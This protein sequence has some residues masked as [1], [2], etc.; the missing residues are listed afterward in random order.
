[1]KKCVL[2]AVT[3]SIAAYKSV[4]LVSDLI[5]KGYDV[6][7]MM[8][9]N[10]TQFIQPLTFSSLTKH[11]TYVDTFDRV[12]HYEV[13]HISLAKKADVV[14]IAPASANVIAK[15]AHGICD[16]MLTTTFLA[17][18]AP[19]IIAPAMNTQMYENPITQDNL[20]RCQK[21]GMK[22]V[23]PESG[24]LACNDIGK[25][26]LASID[27]L[28]EAIEEAIVTKKTLQ[29]KKVLITA[30]PTREAIDPVRYISNYSS[31]KMG[32]ALAK[33]ARNRGAEVTLVSG[34]TTLPIPNGIHFHSITTTKQMLEVCAA[35]F[36]TMDFII[37]SAAP[38]D[39][40]AQQ[41]PQKIKKQGDTLTLTLYKNPDVLAYMGAHKTHQKICGFAAESENALA[42]AK[43]KRIQKNCDMIVV[44]NI[45][46]KGA[47]FQG[48]TNIVTIIDA[49]NETN[50]PMMKKDELAEIILEQLAK[51]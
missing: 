2:I 34:P 39:Y 51:Q 25:G 13:E 20:K 23:E 46:E 4:Q 43:A 40:A 15:V 36:E 22:I 49:D 48:D 21:Y 35:C 32:Y 26:K 9:K 31:G 16:D 10:A 44:N 5:K 50:Y 17:S 45:T 33:A 11:K 29:G 24:R 7:V 6:E 47:G 41:S 42:N 1:M 30:G 18:N 27:L 38:A 28:I 8:S 3:S 12:T 19:K 37:C 14:L